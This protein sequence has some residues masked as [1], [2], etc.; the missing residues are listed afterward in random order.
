MNFLHERPDFGALLEEAARRRG[1]ANP[2]IVEKTTLSPKHFVASHAASKMRSSSKAVQ[3]CPKVG[4]S[5]TDF[6]KTLICM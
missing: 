1:I 4:E 6:P 5:S 3:A 2:A